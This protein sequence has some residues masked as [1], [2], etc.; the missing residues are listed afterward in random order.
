MAVSWR[1]LLVI[2]VVLAGMLL[3]ACGDDG[4]EPSAP[5]PADE[6]VA[7]VEPA[8]DGIVDEEPT[9]EDGAEVEAGGDVFDD[10]P[11]PAGAREMESGEWSGSI[12]GLVPGIGAEP[13]DFTTIE[14]Q[15][16]EVDDSPSDV[17][18]FYKD[19]L[20]GWNEEFVFSG[21]ADGDEG[22]IGVW[23]R[24]DGRV[25][26]WITAGRSDGVTEVVIIRGTA[27]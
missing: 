17:I 12:P 27:D 14:F 7:T 13:G 23:T 24:D 1:W 18:E 4:D 6:G 22:G 5:G 3:A 15:Q 20:E 19:N 8:E 21:G 25:A 26:V 10:V 2:P 9:D 11:A 16:L